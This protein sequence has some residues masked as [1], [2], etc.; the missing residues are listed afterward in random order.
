MIEFSIGKDKY[1]LPSSWYEVT[2]KQ[3]L[4]YS[5]G[6]K[7]LLKILCVFSGADYEIIKKAKIVGLNKIL[8][9]LQFALKDPV[10]GDTTPQIGPYKLP[11]DKN[12]RFD[13]QFEYLSQFEDMR[14]L[15]IETANAKDQ[16]DAYLNSFPKYCA[17]YLQKIRDGEYDAL[18]AMDMVEEVMNYP[19][20]EVMSNGAFFLIE[21][22]SLLTGTEKTSQPVS[23]TRTKTKPG[24]VGS[25][26]NS[27]RMR[28]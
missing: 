15:M 3:Y 16:L 7:D 23:P 1:K 22:T 11:I 25:K 6:N 14:K 4:Q 24:S 2:Y 5:Q 17:I 8:A 20:H 18:K 27:A 19:A 12:K 26:K 28:R 13:I 10:F 9:H 21:L